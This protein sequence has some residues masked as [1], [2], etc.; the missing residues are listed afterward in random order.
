MIVIYTVHTCHIHFILYSSLIHFQLFL[1]LHNHSF[2]C[3]I[4]QMGVS[5]H[6]ILM[7]NL[8]Y[9]QTGL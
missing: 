6:I 8:N 3:L 5:Y 1:Y 2:C 9:E 7:Y 4:L